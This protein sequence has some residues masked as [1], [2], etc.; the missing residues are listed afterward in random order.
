M[1]EPTGVSPK[2][3]S[4]AGSKRPQVLHDPARG[5]LTVLLPLAKTGKD[6]EADGD[7]SPGL[8]EQQVQVDGVLHVS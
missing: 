2:S 4:A 8:E 7:R 6:Q 1:K 5:S 3:R